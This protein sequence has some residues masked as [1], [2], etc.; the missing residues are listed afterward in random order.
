MEEKAT[1]DIK[2]LRNTWSSIR[3]EIKEEFEKKIKL[4]FSQILND[5]Q[6]K[7][8][9]LN[10]MPK[11]KRR[12]EK[13]QSLNQNNTQETQLS[14]Q[15]FQ[16]TTEEAVSDEEHENKK[17][18]KRK[19]TKREKSPKFLALK[20]QTNKNWQKERPNNFNFGPAPKIIEPTSKFSTT[21]IENECQIYY[22][23]KEYV[24]GDDLIKHL[25][26]GTNQYCTISFDFDSL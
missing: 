15:E 26:D 5:E 12:K 3:M 11:K 13:S 17:L 4:K 22:L 18:K 9:F 24:F 19:Q 7:L 6:Q 21:E 25:L 8:E 2:K 16:N 23:F 10:N 20:A 14:T 1:A